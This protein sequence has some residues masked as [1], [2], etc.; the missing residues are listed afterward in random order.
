V[1]CPIC[2]RPRMCFYP[3]VLSHLELFITLP[4]IIYKSY[5]Y[6]Q[7]RGRNSVSNEQVRTLT[8][9]TVHGTKLGVPSPR[10][11]CLTM[12]SALWYRQAAVCLPTSNFW[13]PE[14]FAR[15]SVRMLC[16]WVCLKGAHFYILESVIT[17][18]RKLEIMRWER[19]CPSL[20]P[21]FKWWK[22]TVL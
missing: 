8:W 12:Q 6:T 18:W 1:E 9:Y 16:H 22:V 5:S 19:H 21:V 2:V 4:G 14:G 7:K 10:S 17:T 3:R 20:I 15:Q 11:H 13:T